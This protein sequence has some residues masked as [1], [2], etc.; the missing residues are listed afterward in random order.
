MVSPPRALTVLPASASC[1]TMVVPAAVAGA[2]PHAPVATIANMPRA[3]RVALIFPTRR[4]PSPGNAGRRRPWQDGGPMAKV[5]TAPRPPKA[6]R[7]P[8]VLEKHGDRRVDQYY[9]MREKENPEVIA[10]LE[11]EN[12]YTDAVTAATAPLSE[13]LYYEI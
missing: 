3:A 1:K 5:S 7:R 11:A 2:E 4:P 6:P 13:R 8:K 9:W 10:H 12:A